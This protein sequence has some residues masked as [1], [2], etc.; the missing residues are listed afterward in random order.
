MNHSNFD[1]PNIRSLSHNKKKLKKKSKR[2]LNLLNS[3]NS[4]ITGGNINNNNPLNCSSFNY[5]IGN[6]QSNSFNSAK[7]NNNYK[8]LIISI[9]NLNIGSESQEIINEKSD[10]LNK[11]EIEDFLIYEVK[12]K[13]ENEKDEYER[14]VEKEE[15]IIMEDHKLYSN[16]I[17]IADEV[18]KFYFSYINSDFDLSEKACFMCKNQTYPVDSLLQFRTFEQ[19]L[20]YIKFIMIFRRKLLMI[21]EKKFT[22]NLMD[23]FDF[24]DYYDDKIK[25]KIYFNSVKFCCKFCILGILNKNSALAR[26]LKIIRVSLNGAI[27]DKETSNHND[28]DSHYS[29]EVNNNNNNNLNVTVKESSLSHVSHDNKKIIQNSNNRSNPIVKGK[30]QKWEF[31]FILICKF[32][33]L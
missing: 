13:E 6:N 32:K 26:I 9:P 21:N 18:E 1:N 14:I 27:K 29:K 25:K 11:C 15:N 28:R 5:N 7:R 8:N 17:R 10:E 23:I 20:A 19:F 12:E 16:L 30:H 3:F 4:A 2:R 22:K 31:I 24:I 33:N